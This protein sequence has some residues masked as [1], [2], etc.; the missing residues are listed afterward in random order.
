[1]LRPLP[2]LSLKYLLA[3]DN[4][5]KEFVLDQMRKV[6]LAEIHAR[7]ILAGIA[8]ETCILIENLNF[9]E[10]SAEIN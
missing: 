8:I 2:T 3:V 7:L 5:S 10:I 6:S 9:A 4:S 1:M